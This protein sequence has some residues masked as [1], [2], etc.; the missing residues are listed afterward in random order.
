[1]QQLKRSCSELVSQISQVSESQGAA[2]IAHAAVAAAAHPALSYFNPTFVAR[3]VASVPSATDVVN[4]ASKIIMAASTS[5]AT[6][7]A[8]PS[9]ASSPA[10][11]LSPTSDAFGPL[12]AALRTTGS[13]PVPGAGTHSAVDG[14]DSCIWTGGGGG[15]GGGPSDKGRA[16][17]RAAPPPQKIYSRTPRGLRLNNIAT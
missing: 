5:M 13:L 9:P 1:M 2:D 17:K 16:K 15:G 4:A 12:P 11:L 6:S 3:G 7:A 8:A 10:P 14:N